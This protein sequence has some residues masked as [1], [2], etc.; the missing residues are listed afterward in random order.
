MTF[1]CPALS[2]YR[3]TKTLSVSFSNKCTILA[4]ALSR[5]LDGLIKVL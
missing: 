5:W 1:A 3:N 4:G 2:C